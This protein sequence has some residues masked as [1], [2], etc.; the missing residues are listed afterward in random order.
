MGSLILTVAWLSPEIVSGC[1]IC[2]TA[3]KLLR[4]VVDAHLIACAGKSTVEL[5]IF[6]N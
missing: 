2:T 5:W 4:F 1:L 6:H 3:V